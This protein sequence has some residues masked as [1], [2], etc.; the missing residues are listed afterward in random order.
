M[1]MSPAVSP[2]VTTGTKVAA[3]KTRA[4]TVLASSVVKEAPSNVSTP[5]KDVD[6]SDQLNQEVKQ[7]YVKGAYSTQYCSIYT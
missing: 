5:P 3:A 2:Q 1:A 6:L 7:K 4:L